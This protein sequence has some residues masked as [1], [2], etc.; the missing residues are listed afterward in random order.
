MSPRLSCAVFPNCSQPP[1]HFRPLFLTHA[2]SPLIGRLPQVAVELG[3]APQ[4]RS[5]RASTLVS[6]RCDRKKKHPTMTHDDGKTCPNQVE[7]CN[8]ISSWRI[9]CGRIAAIGRDW[10]QSDVCHFLSTHTC[11]PAHACFRRTLKHFPLKLLLPCAVFL[12]LGT[13]C[14]NIYDKW[15]RS[16]LFWRCLHLLVQPVDLNSA[17]P[18]LS[19]SLSGCQSYLYDC[20]S[21]CVCLSCSPMAS[22]RLRCPLLIKIP[23]FLQHSSL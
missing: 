14:V 6:S 7:I 15:R 1:H 10:S 9:I 4:K 16:I 5:L 19:V 8:F 13:V 3:R 2:C 21:V 11:L 20:A 12:S 23:P 18:F 17:S 22:V